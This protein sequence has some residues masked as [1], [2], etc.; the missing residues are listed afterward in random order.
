VPPTANG[1]ENVVLA[2]ETDARDDIGSADTARNDGWS[3]VD[4][5]VRN[6]SD[7]VIALLTRTE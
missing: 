3:P 1:N 7:S 4:H 5:G 2:G 6:G